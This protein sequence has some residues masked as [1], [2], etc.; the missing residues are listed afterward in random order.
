MFF[1]SK[2]PKTEWEMQQ[3]KE[4]RMEEQVRDL[5]HK[6]RITY[7]EAEHMIKSGQK[8]LLDFK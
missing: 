8:G 1:E 5:M 6:R 7:Q 4:R 2:L 3:E